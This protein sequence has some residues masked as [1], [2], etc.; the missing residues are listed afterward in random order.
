MQN[1]ELCMH[2]ILIRALRENKAYISMAFL[3]SS[4]KFNEFQM[5]ELLYNKLFSQRVNL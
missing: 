3:A 4:E 2:A 5:L 1:Y